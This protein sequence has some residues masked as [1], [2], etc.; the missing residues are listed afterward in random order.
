MTAIPAGTLPDAVD[1]DGEDY[2][3][4]QALNRRVRCTHRYPVCFLTPPF[5]FFSLFAG[6]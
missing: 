6:Y 5:F 4:E 2:G 3:L 1:S